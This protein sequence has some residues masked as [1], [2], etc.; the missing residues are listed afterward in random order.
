MADLTRRRAVIGIMAAGLLFG[1]AIT[2]CTSRTSREKDRRI[3]NEIEEQLAEGLRTCYH[4]HDHD[5][6][7]PPVTTAAAEAWRQAFKQSRADG[8]SAAEAAAYAN[9]LHPDGIE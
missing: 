3:H 9:I 4:D 5:R 1:G 7:L 8:H 2:G 6:S